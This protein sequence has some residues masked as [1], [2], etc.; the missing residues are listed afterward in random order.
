MQRKV[1]VSGVL[2]CYKIR[3][4]PTPAQREV[5]DTWMRAANWSYNQAVE[6]INRDHNRWANTVEL[7]KSIITRASVPVH[8]SWVLRVA[9]RIRARAVQQAADAQNINLRKMR[10]TGKGFRLQFRSR[11]RDPKRCVVL[12]KGPNGP[13]KGFSIINNGSNNKQKTLFGVTVSWGTGG[14]GDGVDLVIRLRDKRKLAQRLSNDGALAEDAK[15]LYDRRVGVYWLSV[16]LDVPVK[17]GR[18]DP[19]T[20]RVVS[21][22]PGCRAFNTYYS[23]DGTHG[24]LLAGKLTSIQRCVQT[25]DV[26]Y[27]R[28]EIEQRYRSRVYGKFRRRRERMKRKINRMSH[29]MR[30]RMANA[31]YDAAHVLL[32]EY[33][34]IVI[35]KFETSKMVRKAGRIVNGKTARAMYTWAH[36]SFRQR[37][38]SKVEMDRS[39]HMRL[40]GE[41]GT[42]KTCGNCGHWNAGLGGRR[43]F[44]CVSCGV[45]IDRDVNG[46]RN[47]LLAELT[48][49][50]GN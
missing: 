47:N 28:M 26:M 22:D 10:T 40:V 38:Q 15:L 8:S 30:C 23:P 32:S 46:A 19:E 36:Y 34:F 13:V 5:L 4:Y 3:V 20:A 24:E 25:I 44:T 16:T 42:S 17:Q 48:Y 21:L 45:E 50:L 14:L 6:I 12:E 7:R 29:L 39:K 2:R 37:L 11:A 27:Q 33:D 18:V 35:P 1:P 9:S 43:T 41:P 31:H 49:V